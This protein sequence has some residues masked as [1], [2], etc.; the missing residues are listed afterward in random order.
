[1]QKISIGF[2]IIYESLIKHNFNCR[3][4]DNELP[5]LKCLGKTEYFIWASFNVLE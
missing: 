3:H 5:V 1:M 4:T 2:Y